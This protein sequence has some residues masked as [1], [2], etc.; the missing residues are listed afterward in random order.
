MASSL[1]AKYNAERV[2]TIRNEPVSFQF[3]RDTMQDG[4]YFLEITD[5]GSGKA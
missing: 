5:L 3:V 2:G 1:E 4:E